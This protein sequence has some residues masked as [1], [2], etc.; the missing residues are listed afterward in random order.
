MTDSGHPQPTRPVEIE[1]PRAGERLRVIRQSGS[2]P[3]TTSRD[4]LKAASIENG[5]ELIPE[6]LEVALASA[7]P[8]AARERAVRLLGHRDRSVTELRDRLG[9]DGYP[10]GVIADAIETLADW[11]YLDDRRFAESFAR[12][13]RAAGWG[14]ARIAAGLARAGVDDDL[15]AVT[16]DT[17]VPE[18]DELLRATERLT[19]LSA[20]GTPAERDR[21]T[22]RL[23]RKGYSYEVARRAIDSLG[24]PPETP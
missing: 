6:D 3:R 8:A 14:R 4:A 15:V 11:G 12:T 21:L 24:E 5:D 2:E 1:T 22:R 9:R 7:E 16:L 17:V 10:C 13:K 23:V 19:R 20:P 18:T